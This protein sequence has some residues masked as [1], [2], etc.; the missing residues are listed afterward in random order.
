[1]MKYILAVLTVLLVRAQAQIPDL[2]EFSQDLE[3]DLPAGTPSPAE[4]PSGLPSNHLF[5]G[6]ELVKELTGELKKMKDEEI[7]HLVLPPGPYLVAPNVPGI[8]EGYR[9]ISTAVS[10]EPMQ[11]GQLLKVVLHADGNFSTAL[12]LSEVPDGQ[13]PPGLDISPVP[14]THLMGL[15]TDIQVL[16]R[17][18]PLI[19]NAFVRLQRQAAAEGITLDRREFVFL[20]IEPG[21]VFFGLER[22]PAAPGGNSGEAQ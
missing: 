13:L 4:E 17:S 7:L 20:P 2:D 16:D 10:G 21:R 14:K 19:L 9:R 8:P 18:S 12:F 1:M 11:S 6:W 3:L 5:S 15:I 22:R